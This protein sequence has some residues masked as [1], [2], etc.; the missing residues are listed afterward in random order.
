MRPDAGSDGLKPESEPGTM[1]SQDG[2]DPCP[3]E[4]P[5]Q[6]LGA[7]P[8]A[9]N[10]NY[11]PVVE[12]GTRLADLLALNV[13]LAERLPRLIWRSCPAPLPACRELDDLIRHL[14]EIEEA[15]AKARSTCLFLWEIASERR[16][17][18]L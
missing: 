4:E 16:A 18:G 9:V 5:P 17:E 3:E 2:H 15:A 11:L 1:L 8:F 14:E 13:G 12:L 7:L 10:A 6:G